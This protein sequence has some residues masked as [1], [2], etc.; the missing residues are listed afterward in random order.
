MADSKRQ[1]IIDAIQTRLETILLTGGYKT[2][3]G[4]NIFVWKTDTIQDSELPCI[5]WRDKS[6]T[7]E[8]I[9]IG[10][11]LHSLQI[12]AEIITSGADAIDKVREMIADV[13]QAVGTDLTWG[14][15]AEDTLPISNEDIQIEQKEKTI[16][17]AK[18]SFVVQ[19]VTEPFNPYN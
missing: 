5:L 10:A 2:N 6:E 9:T 17:G 11:D 19:F 18:V 12:E 4:N 15:I 14:T 8:R 13:I 7:I 3:L 16:A 1:Q